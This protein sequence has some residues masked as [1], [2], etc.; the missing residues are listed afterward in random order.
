MNRT[1][2]D[3]DLT[4]MKIIASIYLKNFK[5]WTNIYDGFTRFLTKS[6]CRRRKKCLLFSLSEV[7]E[8]FY[9]NSYNV[10]QTWDNSFFFLEKENQVYSIVQKKRH[11]LSQHPRRDT[12]QSEI[13]KKQ[14]QHLNFFFSSRP[15]KI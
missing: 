3:I 8:I 4:W 13:M 2:L 14:W 11:M 5:N 12:W 9:R 6:S 1:N 7:L 10:I 15:I